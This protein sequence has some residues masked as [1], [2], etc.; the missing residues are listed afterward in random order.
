M[1]ARLVAD[2]AALDAKLRSA[3]NG[4]KVVDLDFS[5][6]RNAALRANRFA[7]GFIEKCGDDAAVQ[8]AGMA[9]EGVG[10]DGKADDRAI[11]RE[12]EFEAEAARIRRAATEAPVA[13]R[14]GDGSEVFV[15]L[16]HAGLAA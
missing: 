13:G 2:H 7:H 5:R 6:H 3:G 4:T 15:T 9:F 10:D 8:I 16:C 12:Q 1:L 14:V 11:V